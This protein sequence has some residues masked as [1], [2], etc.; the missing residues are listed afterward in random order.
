MLSGAGIAKIKKPAEVHCVLSL[1]SSARRKSFLFAV[2]VSESMINVS[3]QFDPYPTLLLVI[4]TAVG[5][6][7]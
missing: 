1:F 6:T 2:H 4:S 3:L 7:K 5:K